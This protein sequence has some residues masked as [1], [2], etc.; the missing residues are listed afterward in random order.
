MAPLYMFYI[1]YQS[2][3]LSKEGRTSG[4]TNGSQHLKPGCPESVVALGLILLQCI[5]F[6]S[7]KM[8]TTTQSLQIF[9]TKVL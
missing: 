2:E 4:I 3:T 5:I 7:W 8:L 1:H 9:I 6:L